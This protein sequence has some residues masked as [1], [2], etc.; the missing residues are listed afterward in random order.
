MFSQIC[1]TSSSPVTDDD[2]PP[3]IWYNVKTI[4]TSYNF[5]TLFIFYT[6]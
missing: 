5:L 2:L 4:I 3:E 6:F 1:K